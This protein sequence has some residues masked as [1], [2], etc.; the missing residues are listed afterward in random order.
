MH[1]ELNELENFMEENLNN[2]EPI[3]STAYF[4][5]FYELKHFI[6]NLYAIV[7]AG[8]FDISIFNRSKDRKHIDIYLIII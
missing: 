8:N 3:E 4:I 5:T 7:A 6:K 1:N 2:N